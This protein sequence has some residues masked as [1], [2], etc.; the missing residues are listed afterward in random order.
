MWE[1]NNKKIK[2][3]SFIISVV[4]IL[5][6]IF[7]SIFSEPKTTLIDNLNK[8]DIDT[9]IK[10]N[11]TIINIEKIKSQNSFFLIIRLKD[12]SGSIDVLDNK[13]SDLRINQKIQ[14][15]GKISEYKNQLQIENK[16]IKILE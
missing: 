5:I 2:K 16:K 12:F 3:I 13:N 9:Y 4:G 10:I 14:V 6:I 11:G 15:I 8:K 1:S 7:L